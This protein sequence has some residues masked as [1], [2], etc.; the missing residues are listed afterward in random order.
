MNRI[1]HHITGP[2]VIIESFIKWFAVDEFVCD[3][4]PRTQIRDDFRDKKKRIIL[5]KF[6]ERYKCSTL[7]DQQIICNTYQNILEY[8]ASRI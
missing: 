8:S 6:P 2:L 5:Q 3:D 1:F 4:L 7:I